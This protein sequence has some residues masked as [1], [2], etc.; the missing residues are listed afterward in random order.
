[1][2]DQ[3]EKRV[4]FFLFAAATGTMGLPGQ[5]KGVCVMPDIDDG[6]PLQISSSSSRRRRPSAEV[7]RRADEPKTIPTLVQNVRK[8]R[9]EREKREREKNLESQR[10]YTVDPVERRAEEIYQQ[11]RTQ[12]A[13][14]WVENHMAWERYERFQQ[15]REESIKNY[16]WH[17][18]QQTQMDNARRQAERKQDHY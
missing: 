15:Y 10:P 5:K 4:E 3:L 2:K 17:E 18:Y 14:A 12:E 8:A 13:L 16:L 1:L 6:Q 7:V 9:H 11:Q